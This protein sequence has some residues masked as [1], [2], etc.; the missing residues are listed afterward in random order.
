M[1]LVGIFYGDAA[2]ASY[3]L[4]SQ[5]HNLVANYQFPIFAVG[6][7]LFAFSVSSN[8]KMIW[9]TP[10]IL[11]FGLITLV[12]AYFLFWVIPPPSNLGI[13]QRFAIGIPYTLLAIISFTMYRNQK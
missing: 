12:L 10:L 5:I 7:V 11:F 8:E 4:R 13:I 6:L 2:S 3:S 1:Y 9:L